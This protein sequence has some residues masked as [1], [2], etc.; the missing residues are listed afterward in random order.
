MAGF[1]A[2]MI[3]GGGAMK[4]VFSTLAVIRWTHKDNINWMTRIKGVD[5]CIVL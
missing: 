3:F 2:G 1:S 4:M 5:V